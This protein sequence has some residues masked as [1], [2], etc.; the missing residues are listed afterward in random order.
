M[1]YFFRRK[2]PVG[3]DAPDTDVPDAFHWQ[4][5]APTGL[6]LKLGI[7]LRKGISRL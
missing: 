6:G 4:C 7:G 3:L 2:I 5:S 1:H